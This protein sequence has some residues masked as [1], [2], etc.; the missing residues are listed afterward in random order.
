VSSYVVACYLQATN[1][2]TVP[3]N[4]VNANRTNF[5]LTRFANE[6]GNLTL[7][8]ATFFFVGPGNSTA[9]NNGSTSAGNPSLSSIL[10]GAQPSNTTSAGGSGGSGGAMSLELVAPA[11]WSV[12]A[13]MFGAMTYLL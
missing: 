2:V 3:S 1:N 13:V 4:S 9:T 10:S 11:I 6:A 12:L 5:N 7:L 8:G